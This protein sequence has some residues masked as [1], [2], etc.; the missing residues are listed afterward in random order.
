MVDTTVNNAAVAPMPESPPI[1]PFPSPGSANNGANSTDNNNNNSNNNNSN[2]M[3][4][5][6]KSH[7]TTDRQHSYRESD[8]VYMNGRSDLINNETKNRGGNDNRSERLREV[9]GTGDTLSPTQIEAM[10]SSN[11]NNNNSSN[12]IDNSFQAGPMNNNNNNNNGNS[13]E[14]SF[15]AM[16]MGKG[17]SPAMRSNAKSYTYARTLHTQ[18]KQ[19]SNAGESIDRHHSYSENIHDRSSPHVQSQSQHE[20]A[21]G[22]STRTHSHQQQKH[23]P[24]VPGEGSLNHRNSK[25][26]SIHSSFKDELSRT[27]DVMRAFRRLIESISSREEKTGDNGGEIIATKGSV[28]NDVV[29]ISDGQAEE[30]DERGSRVFLL[31][32]GDYF[33]NMCATYGHPLQYSVRTI[34]SC[35]LRYLSAYQFRE[36]ITN[37]P[38]ICQVLNPLSFARMGT[39]LVPPPGSP[40]QSN[41]K[42][43]NTKTNN[44]TR[45]RDKDTDMGKTNTSMHVHVHSRMDSPATGSAEGQGVGNQDLNDNTATSNQNSYR[46]SNNSGISNSNPK[47]G[48][49]GNGGGSNNPKSKNQGKSKYVYVSKPKGM[50]GAQLIQP[51]TTTGKVWI[52]SRPSSRGDDL[53][54]RARPTDMTRHMSNRGMD[55]GGEAISTHAEMD[56]DA[57]DEVSQVLAASRAIGHTHLNNG[58]G[59]LG[60][61]DANNGAN[62]NG[63]DDSIDRGGEGAHGLL[64]RHRSGSSEPVQRGEDSMMVDARGGMDDPS[65]SSRTRT[66]NSHHTHT[67][68]SPRPSSRSI[69]GNGSRGAGVNG[70]RVGGVD[71]GAA[72]PSRL[73]TAS[74]SPNPGSLAGRWSSTP[75]PI[76]SMSG[77]G[78]SMGNRDMDR[79]NAREATRE[80]TREKHRERDLIIASHEAQ[81]ASHSRAHVIGTDPISPPIVSTALDSSA[82]VNSSGLESDNMLHDSGDGVSA[83]EGSVDVDMSGNGDL[84]LGRGLGL[85]GSNTLDRKNTGTESGD[86]MLVVGAEGANVSIPQT[87]PGDLVGMAMSPATKRL[88]RAQDSGALGNVAGVT[89]YLRGVEAERKRESARES[90]RAREREVARGREHERGRD[91]DRDSRDLHACSGVRDSRDMRDREHERDMGREQR[92]LSHMPISGGRSSSHDTMRVMPPSPHHSHPGAYSVGGNSA[93][94]VNH[95]MLAPSPLGHRNTGGIAQ[96]VGSTHLATG[97]APT[98]N[99]FFSPAPGNIPSRPLSP[100]TTVTSAGQIGGGGQLEGNMASEFG[101]SD[102]EIERERGRERGKDIKRERKRGVERKHLLGLERERVVKAERERELELDRQRGLER[103]REREHERERER[104]LERDRDSLAAES[105]VASASRTDYAEMDTDREGHRERDR[106]REHR[107]IR[108]RQERERALDVEGLSRR[109]TSQQDAR[110]R[111][112]RDGHVRVGGLAPGALHTDMG[113]PAVETETDRDTETDVAVQAH[114]HDGIALVKLSGARAID[115]SVVPMARD[116]LSGGANGDGNVHSGYPSANVIITPAIA[117]ENSHVY[118]HTH[119]HSR[120]RGHNTHGNGSGNPQSKKKLRGNT[121]KDAHVDVLNLSGGSIISGSANIVGMGR[122]DIQLST[123]LFHRSSVPMVKPTSHM[124]ATRRLTGASSGSVGQYYERTPPIHAAPQPHILSPSTREREKQE[125]GM[126]DSF[127]NIQGSGVGVGAGAGAGR[128]TA[129]LTSQKLGQL[130]QLQ[131]QDSSSPGGAYRP[132]AEARVWT[133][134]VS[135]RAHGHGVHSHLHTQKSPEQLLQQEQPQQMHGLGFERQRSTAPLPISFGAAPPRRKSQFGTGTGGGG[136]ALETFTPGTDQARGVGGQTSHN[137]RNNNNNNKG[138]G[139]TWGVQQPIHQ[140]AKQHSQKPDRN[141]SDRTEERGSRN[142]LEQALWGTGSPLHSGVIQR[143]LSTYGSGD[144]QPLLHRRNTHQQSG[145]HAT[146]PL[147]ASFG[148]PRRQHGVGEEEYQQQPQTY[149]PVQQQPQLQQMNTQPQQPVMYGQS[150]QQQQSQR[151]ASPY[152]RQYSNQGGGLQQVQ[153][154]DGSSMRRS[155]SQ[156][157]VQLHQPLLQQDQQPQYLNLSRGRKR[158]MAEAAMDEDERGSV[159]RPHQLNPNALNTLQNMQ[160]QQQQQQHPG[161]PLSQANS[162]SIV[163]KQVMYN[164]N[165]QASLADQPQY[166][167]QQQQKHSFSP[168]MGTDLLSP[169]QGT[170]SGG[171]E[172]HSFLQPTNPPLNVP[173]DNKRVSS[174]MQHQH[175]QQPQQKRYVMARAQ[176]DQVQYVQPVRSQSQTTQA[177]SQVMALSTQAQPASVFGASSMQANNYAN[178]TSTMSMKPASGAYIHPIYVG[179]HGRAVTVGTKVSASPQGS[180]QMWMA[181]TAYLP[182]PTGGTGAGVSMVAV[183]MATTTAA[184]PITARA[185]P[186]GTKQSRA[187]AK[188]EAAAAQGHTSGARKSASKHGVS[189]HHSKRSHSHSSKT[190]ELARIPLTAENLKASLYSNHRYRAD[191]DYNVTK[192]LMSMDGMPKPTPLSFLE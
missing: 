84:D 57:N 147:P 20:V 189:K 81:H 1:S 140:Q 115:G 164:M 53:V 187:T 17:D 62:N 159:I 119:S 155:L 106:N 87:P 44:M 179:Q 38:E 47:S 51:L 41:A 191:P 9:I 26:A 102:V 61:I 64:G 174:A 72:P 177:P 139:D 150:Q 126:R 49:M 186:T 167:Q 46:N 125:G 65:K 190:G 129:M 32:S 137:N 120:I 86:G 40:A 59:N 35:R 96:S 19:H 56:K 8:G 33:G 12:S 128:Q 95:D 146:A 37:R 184:A 133:P 30:I 148:A 182:T 31:Q 93:M 145:K 108:E 68:H 163:Y 73:L 23:S 60:Y 141:T 48:A 109:Q 156:M 166:T 157:G 74:L 165:R 99:S 45:S 160:Q 132:S 188:A 75:T 183:P 83:V 5:T 127:G 161:T 25:Q 181:P 36:M 85:G 149:V 3:N 136:V 27:P 178:N 63:S 89:D 34:T 92:P 43:S 42:S 16:P 22:R 97:Y 135:S 130:G 118:A 82:M 67:T 169:R 122:D 79:A 98:I 113:M 6:S 185:A 18:Q 76:N 144:I 103:E 180:N 162:N 15:Q 10:N 14:N 77:M 172:Q 70:S 158:S 94:Y 13:I 153:A 152:Q 21:S 71:L 154:H 105:R 134:A 117:A 28:L 114:D 111:D 66:H 107:I 100:S 112:G 171:G 39:A 110:V 123:E 58:G 143:Q 55:D 170:Y 78:L 116:G 80:R 24:S 151:A 91:R 54:I 90:E 176:D 69:N 131:R 29:F 104:V 192:Y 101:P 50:T 142:L 138:F 7:N 175:Q 4:V 173:K 52:A 88:N 124:T 11:N 2:A 121:H 168:S